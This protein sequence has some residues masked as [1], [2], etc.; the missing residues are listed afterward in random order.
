MPRLAQSLDPDLGR[1]RQEAGHAR[2][3]ERLDGAAISNA[4]RALSKLLDAL[5]KPLKINK[6]A[7]LWA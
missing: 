4:F 1:A 5:D 2:Q 6:N 3:E 7:P